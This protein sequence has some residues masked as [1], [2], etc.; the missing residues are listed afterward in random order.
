MTVQQNYEIL[1][2]KVADRDPGA[3]T[4]LVRLSQRLRNEQPKRWMQPEPL[5]Y[6]LRLNELDIRGC[7]VWQLYSQN[8]ERS[9]E[10]FMAVLVATQ[11]PN[12]AWFPKSD[13]DKNI[14]EVLK[15][16]SFESLP[17]TKDLLKKVETRFK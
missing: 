4:V 14:I 6:V 12:H 5:W 10:R 15:V 2:R 1:L 8:C 9:L 7:F 17:N 16:G 13:G 11:D 3:A